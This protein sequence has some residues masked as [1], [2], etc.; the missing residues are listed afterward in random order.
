VSQHHQIVLV[1]V[2]AVREEVVRLAD[3]MGKVPTAEII[4]VLESEE[5]VHEGWKTLEAG[6]VFSREIKAELSMEFHLDPDGE[7]RLVRRIS[8]KGVDSRQRSQEEQR[9]EKL[10]AEAA[11]QYNLAFHSVIGKALVKALPSLAES[12]GQVVGS[13]KTLDD[14]TH[15]YDLELKIHVEL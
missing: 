4:A 13:V 8:R 6:R 12:V 1:Q 11:P 14:N 3:F 5:S 10:L 9:L 2:D 15:V 7:V